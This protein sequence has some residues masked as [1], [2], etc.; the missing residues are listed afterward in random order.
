MRE[1]A[2]AHERAALHLGLLAFEQIPRMDAKRGG[3]TTEHADRRV[4]SAALY[5]SQVGQ[6]DGCLMGELLLGQSALDS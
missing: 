4:P 2:V 5:A 6:V 1:Y 3:K